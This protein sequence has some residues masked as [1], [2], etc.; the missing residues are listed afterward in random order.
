MWQEVAAELGETDWTSCRSKWQSLRVT[1]KT[2][3]AKLKQKKSGQ[4]T[5]ENIKV[6]WKFFDAMRFIAMSD[7]GNSSESTSNLL[8]VKLVLFTVY[9]FSCVISDR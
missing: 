2:N 4:G 7:E 5:S 6:H 8:L 3:F 1:F 9:L